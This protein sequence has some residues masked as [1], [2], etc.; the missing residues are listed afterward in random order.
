MIP[1]L[2]PYPLLDIAIVVFV[3]ATCWALGIA[4]GSW[5][6]TRFQRKPS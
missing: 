6:A 5:L 4:F 2:T 3:A 1:H